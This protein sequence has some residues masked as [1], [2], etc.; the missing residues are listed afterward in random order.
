MHARCHVLGSLPL[1]PLLRA[2]AL[3]P[4]P[5]SL[6]YSPRTRAIP[7]PI[8]FSQR[9]VLPQAAGVVHVQVVA[10]IT[11][12]NPLA[13]THTH[14]HHTTRA[15]A[16]SIALYFVPIWSCTHPLTDRFI[17]LHRSFPQRSRRIRGFQCS[18][19]QLQWPTFKWSHDD[20]YVARLGEDKIQVYELPSMKL[21]DKKSLTIPGVRDFAYVPPPPFPPFSRLLFWTFFD[22]WCRVSLSICVRGWGVA[23]CTPV[24][25]TFPS[26]RG[27]AP[28]M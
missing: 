10:P 8:F 7:C 16:H 1:V 20:K 17:P 21:L 4:S 5:G 3:P 12:W 15:L 25:I 26:F 18:P 11:T 6:A 22:V 28:L 9:P 27:P 24:R 14:T 2:D 19:K 13:Y 23:P